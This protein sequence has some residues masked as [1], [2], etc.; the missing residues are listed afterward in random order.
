MTGGNA[1]LSASTPSTF[2][3][4]NNVV[5]LG[6]P[7]QG[8]PNGQEVLTVNI[9]GNTL[10]DTTGNVATTT[11]ASFTLY[12]KEISTISTTTLSNTNSKVL[13]TF[14]K[15]IGTFGV[16]KGDEP[17][18]AGGDESKGQIFPGG[19]INDHNSTFDKSHHI[20]EFNYLKRSLQGYHYFGDF[21]GH[22]YFISESI[23]T[24]DAAASLR[25]NSPGYLTEIKSQAELNFISQNVGNRLTG[26][27]AWIGLYQDENDANYSEPAG[28][29]KWLKGGYANVRGG[30]NSAAV[31][32]T[33]SGGTA[34]LTSSIPVSVVQN[35]PKNFLIELPLSGVIS[36]QE[37][38]TINIL[39]NSLFD[40]D[41]NTLSPNQ[42][43]NSVRLRDTKKPILRLTHNKTGQNVLVKGNDVVDLRVESDESLVANPVLTFSGL[44]STTMN[45]GNN[46]S[47]NYSWTVP[48]NFNGTVT[49]SVEGT[50]LQGNK[51]ERTNQTEIYYT[52]DNIAPFV[53]KIKLI[54]D[55]IVRLTFN[56]KIYKSNNSTATLDNANY[57]QL[58]TSQGSLTLKSPT[59][60]SIKQ[61]E[62]EVDL[63]FGF[64]GTPSKG[65]MLEVKLNNTIFDLAGNYSSSLVSNT[66]VELKV[67]EDGDG[68]KD[69]FDKCPG[70][71]AGEKVDASGCS[72]SQ[73]DADN[74]G[75]P[76]YLDQCPNTPS[77]ESADANGCSPSQKDDDDDGVNN[78]IDICPGTPKG[79]KVD[80]YGCTR[81]QSDPDGDGVHKLDDLC[82]N[83][84]KGRIVDNTGCAIKN[85]DEDF[86][87][88]PNE[89]DRCPNTPPGAKVDDKGCVLNPDDEDLDGVLNEFDE[90]PDTPIGVPVDDKGCSKQQRKELEDLLDD[91][92][93]GV[94]NPLDRCP[95]T[96]AGTI[97]DI[98]GCSQVKIDQIISTDSDLDGV[99]N[100]ED[101][102]PDTERGVKVD[103]FGCR[104]DEKDSDFDKVPDEI[105]FCPNTPIGEPVDAN[106]CAKSQ[107]IKDLDLDGV[108]NEEDRC[109]D[110]PF[111]EVVNK[112]GCSPNQVSLDTDMDGVLNEFDLCPKTNLD[113]KVNSDGCSKGQLDEDKDGVINALDRCPET[114]EKAVV[115]EFGCE[116]SQL[117]K[118]DDG[119]GVSNEKDIC[120]GTPPGASVDK[121]GCA[122]KAPKI[123]AHTFNQLKIK[124]MMMFRM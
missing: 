52:I 117:I 91:D 108:P 83:T 98:S 5:N 48:S 29:W 63:E 86:D 9:P 116:L 46:N 69:E 65:Q 50:D 66:K 18:N 33:I 58:S 16:F 35:D 87:G 88:V 89:D 31:S 38:V 103:A 62:T 119:D 47:W 118:D 64:T 40:V 120:P 106:G 81:A 79:E 44:S 92:G 102:C 115:D 94:P 32:L 15:D 123:F 17:N 2:T 68:V 19:I 96:P 51:S 75:I 60:E 43:N 61:N 6:V 97:V 53:E 121:N 82:P 22:S 37:S 90:C 78:K 21:E 70:T 56:E 1:T 77:D 114:P 95:D 111:G 100:E 11:Q 3:L 42:T 112:Y 80:G 74:D 20:I 12:N 14:T 7:V 105:D 84:P 34:S 8:T 26:E 93:D 36:G 39:P 107:I 99:P 41:N 113:E 76:D 104:V 27:G 110:T 49:A 72:Q 10:Y 28:G 73:F 55:S 24:W 13:I 122:F 109:P 59:P 85:N 30:F 54:N 124:E 57:F 101:L 71:P 45:A 67:D 25:N 4:E 23:S